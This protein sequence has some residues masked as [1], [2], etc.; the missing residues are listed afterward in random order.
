MRLAELFSPATAATLRFRGEPYGLNGRSRFDRYRTV[1][2]Y[3]LE[4]EIEQ[5]TTRAC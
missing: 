2:Q 3:R 5:V 4:G 1:A